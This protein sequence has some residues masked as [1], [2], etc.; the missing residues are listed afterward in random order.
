V[1]LETTLIPGARFIIAATAV[2]TAVIGAVGA[3]AWAV[4]AA[5]LSRAFAAGAAFEVVVSVLQTH[6]T[7]V[8]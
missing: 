2:A 7:I 5:L 8:W 6:G 1:V 3:V 4:V